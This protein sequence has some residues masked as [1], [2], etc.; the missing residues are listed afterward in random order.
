MAVKSRFSDY[1]FYPT[2]NMNIMED[3][4]NKRIKYERV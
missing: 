1:N 2:R 4:P 3:Y